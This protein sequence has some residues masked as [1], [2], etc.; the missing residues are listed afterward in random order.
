MNGKRQRHRQTRRAGSRLRFPVN[1]PIV[2]RGVLRRH[3]QTFLLETEPFDTAS[4][5]GDEYPNYRPLLLTFAHDQIEAQM[6]ERLEL[7]VVVEGRWM[8]SPK[9]PSESGFFCVTA[10]WEQPSSSSL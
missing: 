7:V 3:E 4:V 5:S 6:E 8:P 9:D 10:V 2:V 1:T